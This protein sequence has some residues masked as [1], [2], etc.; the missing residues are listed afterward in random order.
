VSF[1][2]DIFL[3][4]YFKIIFSCHFHVSLH[5]FSILCSIL[6]HVMKNWSLAFLSSQRVL[7]FPRKSSWFFSFCFRQKGK[8]IFLRAKFI[9]A[10][11]S[12]QQIWGEAIE[13]CG[14]AKEG[15]Y[16]SFLLGTSTE[17][18]TV[19]LRKPLSC[20]SALNSLIDRLHV[21]YLTTWD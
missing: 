16:V 19:L 7:V 4:T 1:L 6:E 18:I 15:D 11:I 9:A 20:P 8:G 2:Q 13:D 3:Q 14:V 12:G 10:D 17:Y 5:R 21:L